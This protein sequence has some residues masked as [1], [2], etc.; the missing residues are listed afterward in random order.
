MS[1]H[2]FTSKIFS[3]RMGEEFLS[4]CLVTE[5]MDHSELGYQEFFTKFLKSNKP[6]IIRNYLEHFSWNACKDWVKEEEPCLDFFLEHLSPEHQVPVYSCGERYFNSQ[7]WGSPRHQIKYLKDWHFLKES[8]EYLDLKNYSSYTTP[9]YFSS[10]WLNEWLEFRD[11]RNEHDLENLTDYK[12]VYIG[13]Q[14]IIF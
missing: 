1:F 10:D 5:V 14:V 13:P 12:F 4:E 8:K 2:S 6:C 11:L 3:D 7:Y 9:I